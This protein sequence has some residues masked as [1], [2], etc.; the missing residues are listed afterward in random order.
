MEQTG[1]ENYLDLSWILA[2]SEEKMISE[3]A[4]HILFRKLYSLSKIPYKMRKTVEKYLNNP[5]SIYNQQ[6]DT[7]S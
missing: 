3:D 7:H 4:Y 5:K 2:L 1:F 6:K